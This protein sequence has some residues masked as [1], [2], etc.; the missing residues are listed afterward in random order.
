MLSNRDVTSR[1]I[2]IFDLFTK[3]SCLDNFSINARTFS[4][5]ASLVLKR[6]T[7]NQLHPWYASAVIF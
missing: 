2:E 7:K 6:H 1:H 3:I 4:L 5:K